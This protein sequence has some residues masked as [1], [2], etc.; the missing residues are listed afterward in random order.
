MGMYDTV[1]VNCPACGEELFFQS[2]SGECLLRDFTLNNCPN[3][4]LLNVNRHAPIKCDCGTL[5]EVDIERRKPIFYHEKH[6]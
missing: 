5:C 1:I 4:V 6:N 2:K 3:D